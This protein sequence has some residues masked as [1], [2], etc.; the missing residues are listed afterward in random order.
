MRELQQ[1][2][3]F[4]FTLREILENS[5]KGYY[6]VSETYRGIYLGRTKLLPKNNFSVSEG[7]IG[8]R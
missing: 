6:I 2:S 5:L 8:R 1:T 3:V 7:A 4:F